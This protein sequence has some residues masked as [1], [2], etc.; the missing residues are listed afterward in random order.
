MFDLRFNTP[1]TCV[2]SGV[3]GSGKTT[4]IRNLMMYK[5]ENQS[6]FK[7]RP[8]KTFYFY[9]TMQPILEEMLSKNFVDELIQGIPTYEDFVEL[10]SEYKNI[11]GS[12]CIIDD[13]MVNIDKNLVQIFTVGSHHLNCSVIFVTQKLFINN[14]NYRIISTNTHYLFI[15]ASSRDKLQIMN[16]ARQISPSNTSYILDSFKDATKTPYSYLLFDFHPLTPDI[17]KYRTRIFPHEYPIKLYIEKNH[18]ILRNK[19]A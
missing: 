15:M 16:L 3:T 8:I 9:N 14:D 2:V 18:H 13:S 5:N 17:L 7:T 12:C 6:I 11:G 10:T 4:L 19:Y 1:F